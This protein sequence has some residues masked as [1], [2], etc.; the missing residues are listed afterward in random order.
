M[1]FG[2]IHIHISVVNLESS[3]VPTFATTIYDL[4]STRKY[5]SLSTPGIYK[6]LQFGTRVTRGWPTTRESG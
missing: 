3:H 1:G 2:R 5:L 4:A 6:L